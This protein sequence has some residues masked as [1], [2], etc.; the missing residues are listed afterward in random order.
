MKIILIISA[1]L[2]FLISLL[3]VWNKYSR[4][5]NYNILRNS[6]CKNCATILGDLALQDAIKKLEIEKE[7]FKNEATLGSIKL[8]NM[9][10][11][12]PNCGTINYERDL[13]KSAKKV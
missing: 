12:C 10:L 1:S 7:K 2:L 3:K 8:H 4:R 13:Y 5:Y 11:I 9:E 6:K